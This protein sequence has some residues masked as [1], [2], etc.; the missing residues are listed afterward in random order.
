MLINFSTKI[1]LDVQVPIFP[2]DFVKL[3]NGKCEKC[4]K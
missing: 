4:G 1:F 3:K 2:E